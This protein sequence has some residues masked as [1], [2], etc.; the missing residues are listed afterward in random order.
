[1]SFLSKIQC[2][3]YSLSL[4]KN[5]FGKFWR[6]DFSI[7]KI[8]QNGSFAPYLKLE[9]DCLDL[10]HCTTFASLIFHSYYYLLRTFCMSLRHFSASTAHTILFSYS[11][12][13]GNAVLF[14]WRRLWFL[15]HPSPLHV[16]T[17]SRVHGSNHGGQVIFS[18][19]AKVTWKWF[20][21]DGNDAG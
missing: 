8:L 6:F 9:R 11:P 2:S 15:G 1:M 7:S 4:F 13:D 17:E 20:S 21:H 10:S 18:L 16:G 19:I 5:K 3:K 14:Q 12:S